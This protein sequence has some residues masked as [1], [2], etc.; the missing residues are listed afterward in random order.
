VVVTTNNFFLPAMDF[1]P[2]GGAVTRP[3]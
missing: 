1:T 2:P 3:H